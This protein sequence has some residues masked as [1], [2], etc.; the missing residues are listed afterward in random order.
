M[1][2]QP[3]AAYCAVP[4]GDV[5]GW[6]GWV[7]GLRAAPRARMGTLDPSIALPLARV[8]AAAEHGR[9][10]TGERRSAGRR[11][12]SEGSLHRRKASSQAVP[13][14]GTA[15]V[16]T[17][18]CVFNDATSINRTIGGLAWRRHIKTH[19]TVAVRRHACPHQQGTQGL[20]KTC[21]APDARRRCVQCMRA[22]GPQ[23]S[24]AARGQRVRTRTLCCMAAS[25]YVHQGIILAK[26]GLLVDCSCVAQHAREHP[27][28]GAT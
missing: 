6:H 25:T 11:T 24:A 15:Q 16:F 23:S 27:T 14:T 2:S 28:T 8:D 5:H 9:V 4:R 21:V 13:G 20:K 3:P 12:I 17:R 22:H 19:Q 26:H 10:H 18:T 1:A 7:A